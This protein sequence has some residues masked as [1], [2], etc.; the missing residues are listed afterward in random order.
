MTEA[1]KALARMTAEE[2]QRKPRM[3]ERGIKVEPTVKQSDKPASNKAEIAQ[4]TPPSKDDKAKTAP[5]PKDEKKV[6]VATKAD[7]KPAQEI[8]KSEE[9]RKSKDGGKIAHNDRDREQAEHSDKKR[10]AERHDKKHEKEAR[11][12]KEREKAAHAADK[13]RKIVK[14]ETPRYQRAG[15]TEARRSGDRYEI[16][17]RDTRF[18]DIWNERR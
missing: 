7:E 3:A 4:A 15:A 8:Q 6:T 18:T 17:R 9:P 13:H 11:S 10:E 14:D 16:R 2:R 1:R 12:H 5:A